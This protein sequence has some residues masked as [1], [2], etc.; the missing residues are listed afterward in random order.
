MSL[1]GCHAAMAGA[2]HSPA[3]RIPIAEIAVREVTTSSLTKTS[4]AD[5]LRRMPCGRRGDGGAIA[6]QG[7]DF[8]I[9]EAMLAQ[10]LVSVLSVDG[11]AGAN[12]AGRAGE[13]D[14]EP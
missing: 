9:G 13:F 11:R 12:L 1:L 4:S 6:F 7:A 5:R 2:A 3:A 8:L 14:R 10:D